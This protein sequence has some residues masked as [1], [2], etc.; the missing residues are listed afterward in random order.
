MN[1]AGAPLVSVGVPVYN[2]ENFIIECLQSI[3]D[4]SYQ[5]WECI[6]VDNCSSDNTNKLCTEFIKK[7][8]RFKLYRNPELLNI[9]QNWNKVFEYAPEEAAYFKI[10]P[11]D[12]IIFS[13]Y[14]EVMVNLMEENPGVGVASSYRIDGVDVRGRGLDIFEGPVFNGK[15]VFQKEI[16]AQIDVTGSINAMIYKMKYLKMVPDYPKIFSEENL[17]IDMETAC[18]LMMVSDF[19]FVF[20]VMSYTRRHDSSVTDTISIRYKTHYNSKEKILFKYKDL[21]KEI[22][23]HYKDFRLIY[24]SFFLKRKLKGDK[25]CVNWHRKFMARKFTFAEYLKGIL[26]KNRI[27]YKFKK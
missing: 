3:L 8:K 5:N 22:A 26:T 10:V 12:D 14:L 20:N 19:G 23:D 11:A 7:D 16:F 25:D 6:I 21:N 13:T 17:H 1:K 27:V 4:Q 15:E 18:D 9:M 2:G 24:A